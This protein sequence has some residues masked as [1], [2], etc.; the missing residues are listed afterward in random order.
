MRKTLLFLFLL[1][2]QSLFAQDDLMD[3]LNEETQDE[4]RFEYAQATFKSTRIV[5]QQSVENVAKNELMFVIQHRF[6]LINEG[7]YTLYGLDESTIRF[8]LDYGI[9]D[10]VM[11]G[12]GRSSFQ[13]TYDGSIK[14][15]LARQVKGTKTFPVS[16]SYFGNAS[17]S[18]LRP[19]EGEPSLSNRQRMA[20]VNQLLIGRKIS[21]KLSLQI[22]PSMVH[23]NLVEEGQENDIWALGFGG[24]FKLS[25]RVSLNADYV[26]Q[27]NNPE[28]GTLYY[29]MFAL[30]L[31][32]ETG[33]HVFSLHITNSK[34]MMERYFIA[35][36]TGDIANGDLYFGFNINRTFHL[37]KN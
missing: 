11:V 5:N 1:G 3:L 2:T 28:K 23:R 29:D 20:Y 6:G 19:A 27:F 30:G 10:R 17:I 24:R 33:G 18:T 26:Y 4:A 8:G 12:L 14:I 25:Q 32:I 35:E 15:K 36:T 31:D 37:G 7:I 9:N 22:N 21:S 13:K 16:I 34:G